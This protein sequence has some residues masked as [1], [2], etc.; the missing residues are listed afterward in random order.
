MMTRMP[1]MNGESPKISPVSV[2]RSGRTRREGQQ[3]DDGERGEEAVERVAQARAARRPATS[4]V[5]LGD[6]VAAGRA[7]GAAR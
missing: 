6:R 1:D 2:F 4:S 3:Q 5:G 7:R